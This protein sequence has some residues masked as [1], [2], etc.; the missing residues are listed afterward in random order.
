MGFGMDL[1]VPMGFLLRGSDDVLSI[2]NEILWMEDIWN[3]YFGWNVETANFW[4]FLWPFGILDGRFFG[5]ESIDHTARFTRVSFQGD[6][7][8]GSV[9]I[10]RKMPDFMTRIYDLWQWN[11]DSIG[12]LESNKHNWQGSPEKSGKRWTAW[13][14]RWPWCRAG[15]AQWP[16]P[17]RASEKAQKDLLMPRR[18]LE[19]WK[20]GTTTSNTFF[21]VPSGISHSYGTWPVCKWFYLSTMAIFDRKLIANC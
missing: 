7:F 17:S 13:R 21:G 18:A 14:W 4:G 6:F 10:T 2:S 16:V 1:G 11:N 8:R 5:A 19:N 15:M 20:F 12:E 9:E 3:V